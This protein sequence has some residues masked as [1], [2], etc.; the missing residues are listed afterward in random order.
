MAKKRTE[1]V[2]EYAMRKRIKD[3][4]IPRDVVKAINVYW[5]RYRRNRTQADE[6][7][8]TMIAILEN[9]YNIR[10]TFSDRDGMLRVKPFPSQKEYTGVLMT[11][12]LK[13]ITQKEKISYE[14]FY[15][16]MKQV[17]VPFGEEKREAK[18]GGNK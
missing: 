6:E 3:G 11:D 4:I 14:W 2:R 1:V 12:I 9:K 7:A 18:K 8:S 13:A 17:P 10:L 16:R 5:A 15:S